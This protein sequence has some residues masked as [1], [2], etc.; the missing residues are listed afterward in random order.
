LRR[1]GTV[2]KGDG[3]E[4]K[5]YCHMDG[6]PKSGEDERDKAK[7]STGCRCGRED[8]EKTGALIADAV[9]LSAG[10]TIGKKRP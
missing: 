2:P 1:G 3:A 4:D 8:Q 7:D 6:G 9:T 5:S 10:E